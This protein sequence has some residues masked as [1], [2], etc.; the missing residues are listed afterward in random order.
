MARF[1]LHDLEATIEARAASG[2]EASYTKK[3]LDKG[4]QH[5]A[6][7]FGEEAVELV[8]A[9]VE[10]DRDHLIAEAADV[11]FHMLVLLKARGVTLDEVEAALGQRTAMSGLEEK[12]ARKRD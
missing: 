9:T 10:N 4:A 5:C 8:I 1:T 2:G 3:L 7:K 11:M 12:A 6:K